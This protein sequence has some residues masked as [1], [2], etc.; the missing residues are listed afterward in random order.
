[1]EFSQLGWTNII[2]LALRKLCPP[3]RVCNDA[4]CIF[5]DIHLWKVV[6]GSWATETSQQG[7]VLNLFFYLFY[8]IYVPIFVFPPSPG[9]SETTLPPVASTAAAAQAPRPQRTATIGVEHV[10]SRRAFA[11]TRENGLPLKNFE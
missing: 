7:Y 5:H 4:M 3:R 11:P 2:K 1:M 6:R 9:G 10:R 8:S